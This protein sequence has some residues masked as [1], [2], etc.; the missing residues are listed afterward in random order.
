MQNS[1]TSTPILENQQID[2]PKIIRGWALYDWANSVYNL[3]ITSTIFPAYYE[4]ITSGNN[5]EIVLFGRTFINT[6][7][8]NYVLAFAFLIVALLSPILSSIADYKGNKKSFLRF[9]STLGSISCSMLFFFTMDHFVIGLIF[10]I[11]ACIGFWSSLVFYN[12]YLPEIASDIKRD[13]VSAKGFTFGYVGSIILQLLCFVVVFKKEWFGIAAENNALPA[14]ISFVMVGI[15]WFGFAQIPLAILPKGT[16]S[17]KQKSDSNLIK[18]GFLELKK[19]WQE[20]KHKKVLKT[21]LFSYFF[22]NMGVQTV[23]LV[24]TLFGKKELQLPTEGLI[25]TI[26]LIQIV[27]IPGAILIAKLSDKIGNMKALISVIIFWI[28]I[29]IAAYYIKTKIH[30]YILGAFVG[31]V[32]GGIQSLSRSTYS[33]MIPD[34]KDTT[35]YFSF[36]DVTEKVAIVIGLLS[37][38]YIEELTGNMRNSILAIMIFFI[39]GLILLIPIHNKKLN[40]N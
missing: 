17:T 5:G 8:Y 19:V 15:W 18:N 10:V 13:D 33:K 26:L 32:M 20:L 36:F 29:L 28:I 25:V 21:F 6:A 40:A 2:N 34:N 12:S 35:S 14:Q 30:F 9:F 37:Y 22:Y 38:G 39:I 4:G 23:M 16:P 1:N 31:F 11:L 24:A 3:V 7:L 27:A